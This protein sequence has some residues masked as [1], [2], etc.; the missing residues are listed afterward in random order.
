M[1]L[2]I[3]LMKCLLMKEKHLTLL[4][5]FIKW[6]ISLLTSHLIPERIHND[7]QRHIKHV[8]GNI[9]NKDEINSGPRETN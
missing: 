7:L 4:L 3:E 6:C 8:V 1:P 5:C 2:E 9:Q